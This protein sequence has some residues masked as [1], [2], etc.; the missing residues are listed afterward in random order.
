MKDE[1]CTRFI[2]LKPRIRVSF[3]YQT[4]PR[5]QKLTHIVIA[6]NYN[7]FLTMTHNYDDD[8]RRELFCTD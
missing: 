2:I 6:D 5:I 8:K 3:G 4:L 1:I 7:S